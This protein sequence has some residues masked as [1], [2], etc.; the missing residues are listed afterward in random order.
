MRR[1][2]PLQLSSRGEIRSV[3]SSKAAMAT[4][5]AAAAGTVCVNE[6]CVYVCVKAALCYAYA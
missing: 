6:C 4:G 2:R 3:M 1:L 5:A